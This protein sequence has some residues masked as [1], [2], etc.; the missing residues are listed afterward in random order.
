M[1]DELEPPAIVR[2][3]ISNVDRAM[4]LIREAKEIDGFMRQ[5]IRVTVDQMVERGQVLIKAKNL[6]GKG[7][8]WREL[9]LKVGW[10]QRTTQRYMRLATEQAKGDMVSRFESHTHLQLDD[11]P[12]E[13]DS[14][15][16]DALP[17]TPEQRNRLISLIRSARPALGKKLFEGKKKMTDAELKAACP[18]SCERCLRI[19][20]PVGRPCQN[21]LV[22][23]QQAKEKPPEEESDYVLLVRKVATAGRDITKLAGEDKALCDALV[24]CRLMDHAGDSLRCVAFAGTEKIIKM[25]AAGKETEEIVK[26]YDIASGGFVPPRF[27]K[28]K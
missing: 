23:R 6:C 4:E 10:S 16:D 26:A 21:C 5:S 19:G 22:L 20:P 14:S 25:V 9:L 12:G 1:P 15:D 24:A 3:A 27:Q 8:P 7:G 13:E 18:P 2:P 17:L 11:K 28:G